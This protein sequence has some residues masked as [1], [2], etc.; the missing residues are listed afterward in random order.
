MNSFIPE[1]DLHYAHPSDTRRLIDELITEAHTRGIER[2]RIIHGKGTSER[3]YQ[4]YRYLEQDPRV[5]GY[6]DDAGNWGAT[7][8]ELIVDGT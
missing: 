6:D 8:V 5:Y 3:K 2:V 7:I 1:I 4:V